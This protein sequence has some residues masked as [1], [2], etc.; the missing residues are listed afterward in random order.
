M[1][2]LP[3]DE[4]FRELK[5]QQEEEKDSFNK[6][7]KMQPVMYSEGGAEPEEL[8]ELGTNYYKWWLRMIRE[9]LVTFFV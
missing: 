8:A 6:K 4:V 7:W 1:E 9:H 3:R 5:Q 2:L